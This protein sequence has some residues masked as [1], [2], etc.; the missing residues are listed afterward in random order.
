MK[1][2]FNV[3]TSKLAR[4][5]FIAFVL[6]A[7]VPIAAL[8]LFSLSQVS[9]QLRGQTVLRLR[10]AVKSYGL[11]AYERLLF[12]EHEMRMMDMH[13][14]LSRIGSPNLDAELKSRLEEKFD[15]V[16]RYHPDGNYEPFVGGMI[17]FP[18]LTS[19]Q[20]AWLAS[21]QP[22]LVVAGAD[23]RADII[24]LIRLDPAD[25][26]AGLLL[27]CLS[28][29]FIWG[30]DDGNNLPPNAEVCVFAGQGQPLFSSLAMPG[31]QLYHFLKSHLDRAVSGDFEMALDDKEYFAANWSMFVRPRFQTES[32]QFVVLEPKT[33]V[34]APITRFKWVFGLVVVLSIFLVAALSITNIRRSLVPIEALKK[35][36]EHIA[37]KNFGYRVT[38]S[39]GDEFQDLAQTFND[40]SLQLGRQFQALTT[41]SEIDRAILAAK[42][43]AKIA[44]TAIGRL[45]DNFSCHM[46]AISRVNADDRMENLTYLGCM[47][48]V[49][50]IEIRP[51]DPIR[52]ALEVFYQQRTWVIETPQSQTVQFLAGFSSRNLDRVI[53]FPVFHKDRLF[54]L[55]SI[56]LQASD[57]LPSESL[58]LIRQIADQMAVACSTITLIGELKSLTL[59]SM[60]ALARAVDAKSSWTAGH[61][62]RVMRLALAIGRSQELDAEKLGQ[63]QQAALLHDIGKIG[64]SSRI[65]DKPG[66][67]SDEEYCEIK[68]HPVIGDTILKPI[69]AFQALIPIVRQHHERWDGGGY[70]DGLAG[71]AINWGA[72]ILAVA[73]VFDAM[74]SDRPYRKGM[75]PEKAIAIIRS[76]SGRQFD[77][78]AVGAFLQVV[79]SQ[80]QA[81]A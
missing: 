25:A 21:G 1:S 24:L 52:S 40:M 14:K 33:Y 56:G 51:F 37:R 19:S 15:A 32:W 3:Q 39:S 78:Q 81:A 2:Y 79:A 64:I 48:P 44:E 13:L 18:A 28:R 65:L 77:P 20:E 49:T 74:I 69:K 53:I 46:V 29:D 43:F 55:L 80:V 17:H 35:G 5:F 45:L 47:A 9:G 7:L 23:D 36:A 62:S 59:G 76:E 30:L 6:C 31:S 71:E 68:K 61:S 16:G 66:K 60:Q 58:E 38:V 27:G 42:D 63:L 73:D 67:L 54:A 41:R 22:V 4:R 34:F 70:P 72:R 10:H 57:S 11:S 26:S 50:K 12:C 75:D 8:A